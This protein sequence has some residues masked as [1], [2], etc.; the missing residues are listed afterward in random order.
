MTDKEFVPFGVEV[1]VSDLQ[2]SL[3][4]YKDLLDFKVIRVDDSHNFVSLEFNGAVFMIEQRPELV[5]P[6][7]GIVM[8]FFVPDLKS[9]YE[10]LLKKGVTM[11]KPL[12]T[13]DYGAARF[14]VKDP[15][16]YQIKF[17]NR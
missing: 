12:E 2:D 10:S 17:F 1:Y 8:R 13:K 4:F 14:Y 16:G 7:T 6:T 9:Y 3:K 11:H 15:D 5:Q